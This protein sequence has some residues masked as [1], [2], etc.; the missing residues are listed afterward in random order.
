L[1]TALIARCEPAGY[2][3]MVA[4]IGDSANHASIRL[5]AAC[6]FVHAGLLPDVGWKHGRWLDSVLM[7]RPLGPGA[8]RPPAPDQ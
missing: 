1:L 8:S 3:L 4:V 7:I 5:H 6:G 2:R